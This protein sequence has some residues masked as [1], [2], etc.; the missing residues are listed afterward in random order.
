MLP[1]GANLLE[2]SYIGEISTLL[3]CGSLES[4]IDFHNYAY[5]QLKYYYNLCVSVGLNI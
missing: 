4:A 5:E 2:K 1:A 3:V